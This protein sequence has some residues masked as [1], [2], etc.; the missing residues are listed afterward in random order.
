MPLVSAEEFQNVR[1][2]RS[3][4]LLTQ[5]NARLWLTSLPS[6]LRMTRSAFLCAVGRS[7]Q[8]ARISTKVAASTVARC[9]APAVLQFGRPTCKPR[10]LRAFRLRSQSQNAG[11]QHASPGPKLPRA[12]ALLLAGSAASAAAQYTLPTVM[13]SEPHHWHVELHK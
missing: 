13:L 4:K 2:C 9:N 10:L 8:P 11:H 7:S 6:T 1:D 5:D 12:S 3:R